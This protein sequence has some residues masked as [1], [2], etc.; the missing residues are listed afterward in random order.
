MASLIVQT[1]T[2]DTLSGTT[3]K[4]IL[5]G[6]DGS[7]YLFGNDAADTLYGGLGDDTL[8][9]GKGADVIYG[10]D[11]DDWIIYDVTDAASKIFGGND[12]DTLDAS[13]S[14]KAVNIDL[15]K[16]NDIE[17]FLG[18]SGND[19]IAY[20]SNFLEIDGG[21][22]SNDLLTA[23]KA[24]Q[25]VS[26]VAGGDVIQNIERVIGSNYNDVIIVG[27]GQDGNFY[28]N[29]GG[30]ADSLAGGSG[31]DNLLGGAGN[32]TI[33]Y[34]AQDYLDGGAGID[35][36]DLR[37]ETSDVTIDLSDTTAKYKGFENILG[38]S[39]MDTLLGDG[40][41]NLLSAGDGGNWLDGKGGKD[42]I[43]GGEGDDTIVYDSSDLSSN[44]HGGGGTDLLDASTA[45][46]KVTVNLGSY[47]DIENFYGSDYSDS[48]VGN[49]TTQEIKSGDGD[50]T[51]GYDFSTMQDAVIDGGAGSDVLVAINATNG[52]EL[53][54]DPDMITNVERFVGSQ[55]DDTLDA[56][57]SGL[58]WDGGAGNDLLISG[59][60]NDI[61][62]GGAGNDTY[63]FQAGFGNDTIMADTA[64]VG[65]VINFGEISDDIDI[66]RSGSDLVFGVSA[67]NDHLATDTVT[68]KNWY[69]G[70][71]KISKFFVDGG[72]KVFSDF[73]IG[74]DDDN[75]L[76]T[77]AVNA[78][79]EGGAGND[80]IKGGK[81]SD[82]LNGDAGNDTLF[83]NAGDD[84][85]RGGEGNNVLDGGAGNDVLTAEGHDTLLGGL[86]NDTYV[87]YS[88]NSGLVIDNSHTD[89]SNDVVQFADQLLSSYVTFSNDSSDLV[90]NGLDGLELIRF[91]DWKRG[92]DHH[93]SG[94]MFTDQTLTDVQIEALLTDS[95]SG[96]LAG[97]YTLP[98]GITLVKGND[99]DNTLYGTANDDI[100]DGGLGNDILTG[101]DGNDTYRF[102]GTGFGNDTITSSSSNAADIIAVDNIDGYFKSG[103]DLGIYV[104]DNASA[105]DQSIL[106]Q[107]A[108]DGQGSQVNT[109]LINDGSRYYGTKGA[110]DVYKLY[111]GTGDDFSDSSENIFYAGYSSSAQTISGGAGK[112]LLYGGS[113][114]DTIYGGQNDDELYGSGGSDVLAGDDGKDYLNGGKGEDTLTGGTGADVYRYG[115][116]SMYN[117]VHGNDVITASEYNSEDLIFLRNWD[118]PDYIAKSGNDLQIFFWDNTTKKDYSITVQGWYNGDGYQINKYK[119][120]NGDN[121]AI[122]YNLSTG[123]SLGDTDNFSTSNDNIMYSGLS[124]DDQ[125]TGGKGSDWLHGGDG[126]DTISGSLGADTLYGGGGN[127]SLI[128]GAGNDFL[129]GGGGDDTLLGGE[130]NDLLK[131]KSGNDILTG[132]LGNDTYYFELGYGSDTITADNANGIDVLKLGTSNFTTSKNSA[133]DLVFS[134]YANDSTVITD[135]LTLQQWFNK[136]DANRITNFVDSN[137]AAL[138]FDLPQIPKVTNGTSASQSLVGTANSDQIFGLAGN[139][140]LNGMGGTDTL[141][142]GIGADTY[143][144]DLGLSKEHLTIASDQTNSTDTLQFVLN[145]KDLPNWVNTNMS[146]QAV[147][148]GNDLVLTLDTDHSIVLEDWYQSDPGYKVGHLNISAVGANIDLS[149]TLLLGNDSG[150]ADN[151]VGGSAGE[152]IFGLG[153]ND[154]LSGNGGNDILS[155]DRGNDVLDGGAGNDILIVGD[156]S[157]TLTGGSGN[158]IYALELGDGYYFGDSS[159]AYNN[160]ITSDSGNANDSVMISINQI[161]S[162]YAGYRDSLTGNWVDQW[163]NP[164][165]P[166]DRIAIQVN[167][168]DDLV[169]SVIDA[170]NPG[171]YTSFLTIEDWNLDASHKLNTFTFTSDGTYTI[172]NDLAW[173][174]FTGTVAASS[175]DTFTGDGDNNY[176]AGNG[177][178]DT[179]I[180]GDGNDTYAFTAGQGSILI[181]KGDTNNQDTLRLILDTNSI[182]SAS[183]WSPMVD[184][185]GN[186]LM[187]SLDDANSLTLQGWYEDPKYQIHNLMLS[188][189][190]TGALAGTSL[191]LSYSILLGGEGVDTLTGGGSAELIFGG[192][193][194]DSISGGAGDDVLSGDDGNDTINGGAGDDIMFGS[195][196]NDK[197]YGGDGFDMLQGGEGVD[198]LYGGGGNDVYFVSS[199]GVEWDNIGGYDGGTNLDILAADSGNYNDKVYFDKYMTMG[200]LRLSTTGNNNTD[201][202]ISKHS[203]YTDS[204]TG[205]DMNGNWGTHTNTYSW[206]EELLRIEK[207]GE[208]ANYRP[209]FHFLSDDSNHTIQWNAGSSPSWK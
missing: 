126:S 111:T 110:T 172:G 116:G 152:L 113:S 1:N 18:S 163:T 186:D 105:K 102:T 95:V 45:I 28:F 144:F 66:S 189:P 9:G 199:H 88:W 76:Q 184:R 176:L 149:Y 134:F 195:S 109:L 59:T 37:D 197:L 190:G 11:G 206:D 81:G 75:K 14:I 166:H 100:L 38:G 8:D 43:T 4:D 27:D 181:A 167:N 207:F 5:Y 99:S 120:K 97:D 154:S 159:S 86:G 64:N 85:L 29:G 80:V 117:A 65:D 177:G 26:I 145:A 92:N 119:S 12:T 19:T 170:Y 187:L 123:T 51:I 165:S 25:G 69:S 191:D 151:L 204:W 130:G 20:N 57:M 94:I 15:M 7:D 16:Y 194:N 24:K 60:G 58:T 136:T 143:V 44:V 47:S 164:V 135:T 101:G 50:D 198:T 150:I 63:V 156:G 35:V 17:V 142:G 124:G 132:G 46:R 36:L 155:G 179:L 157:D 23:A 180:G 137:N 13:A 208:S 174:K 61:L 112:D 83:G 193:G 79:L 40:K 160:V 6:N 98:G 122:L 169:L 139:D 31:S 133:N 39:G 171:H 2:G 128:G 55:Y 141:T 48:I 201:L 173:H 82:L 147:Q 146:P 108:L 158:D 106:L 3:T 161:G 73:V 138:D 42:T 41:T 67:G 77:S 168:D 107:G 121:Q 175:N 131:G 153:G 182:Q 74:N 140:S 32:D 71:K 91:K 87:S 178:V 183:N 200:N 96:G 188:V 205:Y 209:T 78:Y 103:S 118:V 162:D 10:N 30:G 196:G 115:S 54:I 192:A 22:G 53:S 90:M 89:N 114:S 129:S 202:L 70:S 93:V 185:V 33:L 127:D 21:E 56:G 49:A 148:E 104:W 125:I 52:I 68:L 34:D 62:R 84:K 72:L 203:E